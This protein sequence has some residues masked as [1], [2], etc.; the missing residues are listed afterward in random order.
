MFNLFYTCKTDVLRGIRCMKTD[1]SIYIKNLTSISLYIYIVHVSLFCCAA[2]ILLLIITLNLQ[3]LI[4]LK[5]NKTLKIH[6]L[7][8]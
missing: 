5:K 4:K 3:K 2:E 1:T 8:L 7:N 6:F